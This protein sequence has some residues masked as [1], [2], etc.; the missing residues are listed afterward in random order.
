MNGRKR[1]YSAVDK[2]AFRRKVQG[3]LDA[4][5]AIGSFVVHEVVN[6]HATFACNQRFLAAWTDTPTSETLLGFGDVDDSAVLE[7]ERQL[8]IC[9]RLPLDVP[10]RKRLRENRDSATLKS[11]T[12]L[13]PRSLRCIS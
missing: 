10:C 8:D 5:C 1:H 9:H 13:S 4:L 12:I 2:N 6:G 3:G 7:A 11:L